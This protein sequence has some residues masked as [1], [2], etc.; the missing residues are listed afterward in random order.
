M[1]FGLFTG[2]G[3]NALSLSLG[4]TA[5]A[6]TACNEGLGGIDFSTSSDKKSK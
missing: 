3:Q 4:T 5:P 2:L 1:V 6:S